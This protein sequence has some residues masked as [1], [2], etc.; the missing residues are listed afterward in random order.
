MSA[1]YIL[2][3]DIDG[4]LTGDET[5]LKY[6]A[7]RIAKLR[8][9]GKLLLYLTTGRRLQQVLDGFEYEFLPMADAIIGQVGTEIYLPPFNPDMAPLQAWD[10]KLKAEFKRPVAEGFLE[11][12]EGVVMQDGVFNTPLKASYF[13][14]KV[15][16]PE[17]AVKTVIERVQAVGGGYQVVWSSGRDLD[18]LPE[19]S[20][21]GKAI[22]FLTQYMGT[23]A[24]TVLVAGDTGN[25]ISMFAE[26]GRGVIVGNAKPELKQFK[27]DHSDSEV[28]LAQSFY[29]A[30]VAE[31]L[32]HYGVIDS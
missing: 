3:S 31:G 30:G 13:M 12:I 29:A 6:L 32:K 10:T 17:E 2:A 8:S 16:N 24:A 15:A 4:T 9:E 18:I 26:F 19:S 28:Y 25:D 21:K 27:L 14:D 20:G 22:R 1:P 5:A 11:G 23:E 7:E